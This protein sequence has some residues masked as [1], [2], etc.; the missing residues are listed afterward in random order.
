[1]NLLSLKE[2][3]YPSCFGLPIYVVDQED[4]NQ[5]SF[6]FFFL[7]GRGCCRK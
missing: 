4:R 6:F 1:M 3:K 5:E 7:P 2:M